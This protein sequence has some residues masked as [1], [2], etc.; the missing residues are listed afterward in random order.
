[1]FPE[2][3]W[4][5]IAAATLNGDPAGR[6]ALEALCRAY[7]SAVRAYVQASGLSREEA[8][9]VTQEFFAALVKS[10][11]WQRADQ[12]RG[13]FRSFLLG[14]VN[15]VMADHLRHQGAEKRGGGTQLLALDELPEAAEPADAT[16]ALSFDR[17]WAGRVMEQALG[18]LMAES[19]DQAELRVLLRF[20]PLGE[21]VPAYSSVAQELGCT[22]MAL[23]VRVSRF[24]R[25]FREHVENEVARTVSE[26][27][28]VREELRHLEAVLADPGF[29]QVQG[30]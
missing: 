7:S 25:R 15:R 13:R 11:L 17:A 19:D 9:D 29:M 30:G 22:E 1:M 26:P 28:Q 4:T 14:A 3:S 5:L 10:K 2:T 20:L 21:D 23:K 18:R 12:A 8:E 27:E 24:R 16:S 6:A